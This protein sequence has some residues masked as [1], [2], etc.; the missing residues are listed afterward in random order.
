M[1]A[2]INGHERDKGLIIASEFTR[3]GGVVQTSRAMLNSLSQE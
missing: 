2:L 3:A 1:Q